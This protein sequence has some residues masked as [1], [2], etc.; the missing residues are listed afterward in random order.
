MSHIVHHDMLKLGLTYEQV[1]DWTR[2]G[3]LKLTAP[4]QGAG[5]RRRYEPGEVEVARRM[6]RYI[7]AGVTPAAAACAAR[8]DGWIAPDVRV[9]LDYP[10][11][12]ADG[13]H[14]T[15]ARHRAV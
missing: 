5:Y 11:Q 4:S 15:T 13:R 3:W 2:R 1:Q 9:V 6:V 14:R 8:H 7:A 12:G 10:R